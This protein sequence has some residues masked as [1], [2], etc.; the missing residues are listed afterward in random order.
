M[1]QVVILKQEGQEKEI[2]CDP[3]DP[4]IFAQD[5]YLQERVRGHLY[6]AQSTTINLSHEP[7]WDKNWHCL[8]IPLTDNCNLLCK[9]CP[10][11]SKYLRKDIV[12][13][14]FKKYLSR[15][16]PDNFESLLLSDFGEPLIRKDFIEILHYVKTQ[17]FKHV[18]IVTT[19]T[20]LGEAWCKVIVEENL[21][22]KILISIEASS[23][24]LYEHIRGADF[25]LMKTNVKRLTDH[26]K[27]TGS[28]YPVLYF[29]AV[30]LKK[31]ID[32]LPGIMDLAHELGIMYV[33]FVHL[34]AVPSDIYKDRREELGDKLYF[35][36]Q[37]L[38]TCDREHILR[39][40]KEIDRK[41]KD[42]QIPYL[43]P[44]EYFAGHPEAPLIEENNSEEKKGCHMPYT[45][46]QVDPEGNVYPCCQISRRY[47]V[48]N[49]ND[50]DFEGIWNSEKFVE[51]REGLTNG[52]PNR[53]CAV[54]NV[55]NGKRF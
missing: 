2:F 3:S 22:H 53:W 18:Q 55:Y 43:P 33:Y 52:K 49:L 21:L 16:S 36:D 41:S 25:N 44:E 9:H 13:E 37:H 40:F 30:C 29:N 31:N 50:Q 28:P 12:P 8:Q 45:W 19:G 54:C 46:A 20:L 23:K 34:N 35:E 4:R 47:S 24:E 1:T 32:E 10:R 26:K 42:Y 5:F 48:G 17:G 7:I 38:N 39:V 27:S 51:F 15:F 11:E 14:N 6:E